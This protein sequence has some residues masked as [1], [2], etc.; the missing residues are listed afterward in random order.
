MDSRPSSKYLICQLS[1]LGLKVSG[2]RSESSVLLQFLEKGQAAQA[3]LPF[4]VLPH[5]QE[6]VC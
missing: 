4:P 2:V 5:Y 1:I 6:V 3:G